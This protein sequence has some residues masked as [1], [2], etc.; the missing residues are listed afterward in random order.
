MG[1]VG[2][3]VSLAL[4]VAL[5]MTAN[6]RAEVVSY[7]GTTADWD[8]PIFTLILD[9]DSTN[10][11]AW[12][13]AYRTPL[14][15]VA[16]T[17]DR[18]S[19]TVLG[20]GQYDI[21]GFSVRVGDPNHVSGLNNFVRTLDVGSQTGLGAVPGNLEGLDV[22][23]NGSTIFYFGIDDYVALETLYFEFQS[24]QVAP[25]SQNPVYISFY[26][27]PIES[28][29]VPEPA[30]LALMG[31]GLAGLGIARARRKK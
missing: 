15:D 7:L 17:G 27:T 18:K 4:V 20:L 6:L 30:T 19:F 11:T 28:G 13:S 12:E 3:L 23:T 2:S 25:W 21:T 1:G 24:S 9:K 10:A 31:L 14:S 22:N 29:D 26:G 5:L 8:D 16:G